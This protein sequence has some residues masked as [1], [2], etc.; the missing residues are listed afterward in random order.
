[1]ISCYPNR[2][3]ELFMDDWYQAPALAIMLMKN[4]NSVIKNNKNWCKNNKH[5]S[6]ISELDVVQ[7]HHWG[8]CDGGNCEET[9]NKVISI[10]QQIEVYWEN[11]N[12]PVMMIISKSFQKWW[13]NNEL[14]ERCS[15]WHDVHPNELS[16][17]AS[18]MKMMWGKHSFIV[19]PFI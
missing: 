3:R 15:T 12:F 5:K 9:A 8:S 18:T 13:Q 6:L 19:C 14:L 4:L 7:N 11:Q 1:M 2:M 17:I 16:L 10:L